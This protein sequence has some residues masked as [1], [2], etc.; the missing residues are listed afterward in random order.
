MDYIIGY[1]SDS[2][3]GPRT[4][5]LNA[6]AREILERR[7]QQGNSPWVF[8]SV[9]D[10]SRPQC[11]GLPL[12][13]RARREAGIEDVRLHDLRHTVASQA[14]MNGVPLPVVARLLGHSNVR[15]TMRYAHVGDREIKAAAERV[16]RAVHSAMGGATRAGTTPG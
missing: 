8:P 10:P 14:A 1:L 9:R 7:T 3:T 11:R 2:K 16:G 5:L 13:Y 6:R 4:V 15:M 12:W